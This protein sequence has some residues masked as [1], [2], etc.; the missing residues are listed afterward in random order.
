MQYLQSNSRLLTSL[1]SILR[2]CLLFSHIRIMELPGI[3]VTDI[4]DN[5]RFCREPFGENVQPHALP[6][7]KLSNTLW[8]SGHNYRMRINSL[9]ILIFP[10]PSGRQTDL[11]QRRVPSCLTWICQ[12]HTWHGL[13]CMF[14]WCSDDCWR[15]ASWNGPFRPRIVPFFRIRQSMQFL[16]QIL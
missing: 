9:G 1:S 8:T 16:V 5:S 6:S 11:D 10:S 3:R 15:C 14:R 12:N 4:H 13:F 7:F 2:F